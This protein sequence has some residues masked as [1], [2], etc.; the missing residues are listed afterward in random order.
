[1]D[2]IK[3][4]PH[5]LSVA[6]QVYKFLS[7]IGSLSEKTMLAKYIKKKLIEFLPGA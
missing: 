7:N 5:I 6:K 1:M 3:N 4:L 2:A